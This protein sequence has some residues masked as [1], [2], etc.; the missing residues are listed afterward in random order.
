MSQL[1]TVGRF[2]DETSRRRTALTAQALQWSLDGELGDSVRR[3]D[4][5]LRASA[6]DLPRLR[7]EEAGFVAGTAARLTVTVC[8]PFTGDGRFFATRASRPPLADPP[9]GDWA[10]RAD[11]GPVLRLPEN[12]THDVDATT[13]RA[14]A[15][16][17][18]DAVEAHLAALRAEA[19]EE[20]TRLS[21]DLLELARTRAADLR[22]R[23]ALESE[24][25]VGV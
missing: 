14:W 6:P 22:R 10:H 23:R 13:V 16:R 20:T 17:A 5:V 25:G 7:R 3:V 21:A 11:A 4:E 15:A 8:V 9:V 1:F 19:A 12:F 24:L 18:V 2:A